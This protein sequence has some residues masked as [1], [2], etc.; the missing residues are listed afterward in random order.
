MAKLKGVIQMTG[1]IGDLSIY[2]R[3]G[4]SELIVCTRGGISKE[5]LESDSKLVKT[6]SC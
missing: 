3:K 4:S 1:R 2:K 5:R 6:G